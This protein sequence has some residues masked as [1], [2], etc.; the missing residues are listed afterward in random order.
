MCL[1]GLLSY[2]LT[3]AESGHRRVLDAHLVIPVGNLSPREGKERASGHAATWRW[4]HSAPQ[5]PS[6]PNPL[7]PPWPGTPRHETALGTY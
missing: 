7:F 6:L 4:S 3:V 1:Y 5:N 2:F